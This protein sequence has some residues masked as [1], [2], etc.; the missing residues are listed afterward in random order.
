MGCREVVGQGSTSVMYVS[1]SM[2]ESRVYLKI[3]QINA[4]GD[5]HVDFSDVHKAKSGF[6]DRVKTDVGSIFDIAARGGVYGRTRES[7]PAMNVSLFCMPLFV[8]F[9]DIQVQG[10]RCCGRVEVYLGSS[11]GDVQ[12]GVKP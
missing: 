6:F 10:K 7:F 11:R 12:V 1:L 3:H 9:S 5:A 4:S 2:P 8:W